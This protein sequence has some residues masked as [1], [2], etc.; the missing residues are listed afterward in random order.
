[1]NYCLTVATFGFQSC[2][3]RAQRG[4][5]TQKQ[6][7][8]T[9]NRCKLEL[10]LFEIFEMG[11]VGGLPIH[12]III[13]VASNF[14]ELPVEARLNE[15]DT[16]KWKWMQKIKSEKDKY[17]QKKYLS[18][19]FKWLLRHHHCCYLNKWVVLK[20]VGVRVIRINTIY[21]A[22]IRL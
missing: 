22:T 8:S 15:L 17:Q 1:M 12:F 5:L 10:F 3:S 4:K 6:S 18:T 21:F 7:N 14:I 2:R 19:L 9:K 16:G 13:S 11:K 20:H